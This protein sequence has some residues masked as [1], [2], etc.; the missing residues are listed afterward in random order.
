VSEVGLDSQRKKSPTSGGSPPDR[1]RRR[2]KHWVGK[3]NPADKGGRRVAGR[4]KSL[5]SIRLRPG[6]NHF[7]S[8]RG[9]WGASDSKKPT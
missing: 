2:E 4:K 9:W 5:R 1:I 6:K 8:R 7:C 3:E